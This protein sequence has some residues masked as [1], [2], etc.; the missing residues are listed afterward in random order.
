MIE[1]LISLIAGYSPLVLIA[2]RVI[3]DRKLYYV[4]HLLPFHSPFTPHY[5]SP[6][7]AETPAHPRLRTWSLLLPLTEIRRTS[8]HSPSF[9]PL[10][11]I[12]ISFF[13]EVHCNCVD[14][15]E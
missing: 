4:E 14:V 5:P 3:E 10:S 2:L 15:I 6:L 7:K 11:H 12:F 1:H 8:F 9:L 13:T